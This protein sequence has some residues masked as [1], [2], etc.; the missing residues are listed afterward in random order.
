MHLQ[1]PV[2]PLFNASATFLAL[3]SELSHSFVTKNQKE[4][5]PGMSVLDQNTEGENK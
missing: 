2:V 4:K 1:L 3:L 5:G